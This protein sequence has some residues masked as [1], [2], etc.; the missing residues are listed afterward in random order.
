[1]TPAISILLPVYNGAKYLRPCIASVLEQSFTEFELLIVDDYSSDHSRAILEEFRD[2]RIRITY[3]SA[4]AGLFE[5]L[6]E[7]LGQASAPVVRFL[8]Q[9]DILI[10]H[11]LKTETRFLAE[12][13]GVVISYCRA[14]VIDEHGKT[15]G[16]W[17]YHEP[18]VIDPPL[19]WQLFYYYG[20][21]P[22]NLSTVCLRRDVALALGGFDVSFRVGGDYEMW[23]RMCTR[24]SLGI[25]DHHLLNIRSHGQQLSVSRSSGVAAIADDRRIRATLLERL[26]AQVRPWAR[27]YAILR[28]GALNTHHWLRC[29]AKGRGGEVAAIARIMG[30]KDLALGLFAWIITLD[31]RLWRPRPRFWPAGAWDHQ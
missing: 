30:L 25:I 18:E 16:K 2:P 28:P 7:L 5:S 4:N 17:E 23:V 27:L 24:G 13:P 6:N 15:V 9:D 26:P 31:N 29:L 20:C 1:M 11:C 12:H 3:H 14:I 8:C 21:L 10:G 19:A 22:G